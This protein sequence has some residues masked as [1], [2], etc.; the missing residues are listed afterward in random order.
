MMLTTRLFVFLLHHLWRVMRWTGLTVYHGI[1]VLYRRR[2]GQTAG[3][4]L[5]PP[6]GVYRSLAAGR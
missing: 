1:S 6:N 5:A 4:R 3:L 2:Q